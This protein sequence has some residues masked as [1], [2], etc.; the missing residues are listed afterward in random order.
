VDLSILYAYFPCY[1]RDLDE[2]ELGPRLLSV[3]RQS[4]AFL[5]AQNPDAFAERQQFLALIEAGLGDIDL[6]D[7]TEVITHLYRCW[8]EARGAPLYASP[9]LFKETSQ[10]V[11]F[12][13]LKQRFPRLRMIAIVRDPRDNFAAIHSG[14]DTYYATLG[15]DRIA[16][17]ASHIN[18]ARMDLLAA[19]LNAR[20]YPDA[21]HVLRFEDLVENPEASMREVARF[22]DIDFDTNMLAPRVGGLAYQGNSY[23][24]ARLDGISCDHVGAWRQRIP[25][26]AAQ[27]IE[28]W[29]ADAMQDW[30][31]QP[32]FDAGE[33]QQA[34]AEFYAA[35]N[36]RYFY[37]DRFCRH[38]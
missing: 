28:Y 32:E 7:K 27:V 34:F 4:A 19:R 9:F 5:D 35:Y 11:F 21:F 24:T 33:S 20:R 2:T 25:E 30:G 8:S 13:E 14:I 6:R 22:L 17:L 37:N 26:S 12:D 23:S 15:E 31:Y 29:L 1:S 38:A 16:A 3:L 10:S 36:G 18:R